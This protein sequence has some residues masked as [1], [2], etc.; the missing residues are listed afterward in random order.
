MRS[1]AF[2]GAIDEF[3]DASQTLATAMGAARLLINAGVDEAK[4]LPHLQTAIAACAR[5]AAVSKEL[6]RMFPDA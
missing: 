1:P 3:A 5:I 2:L 6:N 4:V